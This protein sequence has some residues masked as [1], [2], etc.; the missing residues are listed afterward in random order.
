MRFS[1]WTV[2]Q[3]KSFPRGKERHTSEKRGT[4]R[5]EKKLISGQRGRSSWGRNKIRAKTDIWCRRKNC[6]KSIPNR[7]GETISYLGLPRRKAGHKGL[8]ESRR[9][10]YGERDEEVCKVLLN[11][12]MYKGKIL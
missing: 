1:L 7:L 10:R 5:T 12:G 9:K 2:V 8:I 4:L 11:T 3:N 6:S